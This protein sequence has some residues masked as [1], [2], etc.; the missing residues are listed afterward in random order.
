MGDNTVK[1]KYIF[2]NDYNPK[3]AN[4]AFGNATPNGEIVVHFYFERDA[5]PYEQ[6]FELKK[7]GFLGECIKREPENKK[8]IRYVQS[9][10]ILTREEAKG[11]GEWLINLASTEMEE[12]D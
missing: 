2:D 5:L 8:Y 11:L 4:G 12:D 6:E 1:F 7:G 10:L 3:Y 9:G